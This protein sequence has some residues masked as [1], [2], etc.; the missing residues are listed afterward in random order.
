V[1][2]PPRL[3]DFI[4]DGWHV[5]DPG[6]PILWNWHID[7]ISEHLE[8]VARGEIRKLV[9]NIPPGHAKSIIVAVM[10]PAWMWIWKPEWRALFSSYAQ[11]LANRD[12]VRCRDVISSPWYQEQ[13]APRWRLKGDQNVKSYF[14]NSRQGFRL[15][16]S[17]SGKTTGHRGDTIIVDDPMNAGDRHSKLKRDKVID[18]WDRSMSSRLND[19]RTGARIVIMQRLHEDDLTGHIL[20]KGGYE[21][22]CLPSE[23]DPDRRAVT[24][25]FLPNGERKELFRDPRAERGELL[26]PSLFTPEVIAEA[27]VDLADDFHAQHQHNP[28]P[29]EGGMFKKHYWRYWHYEGHPLPP[30]KVQLP[31]GTILEVPSVPLPKTF[32]RMIQSWDMAFKGKDSSDYVAGQVW[33]Q[34]GADKFLLEQVRDQLGFDGTVKAVKDTTKR[35]P[36]ARAK[37]V[38]DKANGPAVIDHL[39]HEISGLVAVEPRGSKEARAWTAE[40]DIKAGNVYLPH[41]AIASWVPDYIAEFAAFPK[42]AKDDQ[43]DATTQALDQLANS[44]FGGLYGQ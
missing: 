13:F 27:K 21:V 18:W 23:F 35:H 17:A 20:K 16:L 2:E 6:L 24:Y 30:V 36:L 26:F 19:K 5:V 12:S 33:G 28:T 42:G 43:V 37:Y 29:A 22:L 11:E 1:T 4:R 38:E 32:Q 25:I 39:K 44:A 10:W 9:I 7:A 15:S 14:A 8:A 40:P 3:S 31:D 34:K 41:P